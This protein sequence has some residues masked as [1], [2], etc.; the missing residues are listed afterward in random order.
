MGR[1]TISSVRGSGG[2]GVGRRWTRWLVVL[3]ALSGLAGGCAEAPVD[4]QPYTVVREASLQRGDAVPV[5]AE[6]ERILTVS[7]RI[8]TTNVGDRLEFDLET[9]E[10]LRLVEFRADD[11]QAE[12]REVVFRGVLLDDLLAFA[13]ADADATEVLT[14]A[15]NDYA[16]PIPIGDRELGALVA[17]RTDGETMPIERYGPTRIVYPNVEVAFEPV[18]FDPK[19]TWQLDR[20]EIR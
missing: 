18:E 1:T 20:L 4:D 10:R 13:G 6:G 14:V 3:V 19:W 2:L 5:P 12:G 11:Y 9:L 17:T 15:L 7:G 8:D 16:F